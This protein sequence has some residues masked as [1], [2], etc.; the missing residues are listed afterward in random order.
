VEIDRPTS[1]AIG[2]DGAIYVTR[3]GTS[4]DIGQVLRIAP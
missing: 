3:C 4:K 2:P 1:V